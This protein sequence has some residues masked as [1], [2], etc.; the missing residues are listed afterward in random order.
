M[1]RL[2]RG[3]TPVRNVRISDD[4]WFAAL[5]RAHSEGKDLSVVIREMLKRYGNRRGLRA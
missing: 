2:K 5:E 3:K 1:P 4:I